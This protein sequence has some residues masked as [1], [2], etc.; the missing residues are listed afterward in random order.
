MDG[1][2]PE[3][4]DVVEVHDAT[5]QIIEIEALGICRLEVVY[6]LKRND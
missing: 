2:G 3:D 5:A 1:I 4:L 6:L